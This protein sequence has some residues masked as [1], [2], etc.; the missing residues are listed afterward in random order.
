MPLT[1][2]TLSSFSP[3]HSQQG[4]IPCGQTCLKHTLK[5]GSRRRLRLAQQRA[6]QGRPLLPGLRQPVSLDG[7]EDLGGGM[8]AGG[9]A[10]GEGERERERAIGTPPPPPATPLIS[11]LS[12]LLSVGASSAST[13]STCAA[14]ASASTPRTSASSSSGE[15]GGEAGARERWGVRGR[16]SER[17]AAGPLSGPLPSQ[18]LSPFRPLSSVCARLKKRGRGTCF[19][20]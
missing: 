5:N 19:F 20:L 10:R 3:L 16:E 12:P 11:S 9:R 7:R 6:R 15:N 17:A 2:Y 13:A 14:S 8:S 1:L 18:P 4:F